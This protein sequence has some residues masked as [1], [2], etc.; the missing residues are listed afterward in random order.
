MGETFQALGCRNSRVL[1]EDLLARTKQIRPGLL[2]KESLLHGGPEKNF[3][4]VEI[5]ETRSCPPA[6]GLGISYYNKETL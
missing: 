4:S 1:H 2:R 3:A 5:R 6:G